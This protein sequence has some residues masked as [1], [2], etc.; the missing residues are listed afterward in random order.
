MRSASET[1]ST[2]FVAPNKTDAE[3]KAIEGKILTE[4]WHTE[5]RFLQ[6]TR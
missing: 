5:D 1:P 4:S 6:T 3:V 2:L